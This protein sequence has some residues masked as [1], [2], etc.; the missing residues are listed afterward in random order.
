MKNEK[1][2]EHESYGMIQICRYRGGEKNFFGSAIPHEGGVSIEIFEGKHTRSLSSDWYFPKK[3]LVE[4]RLTENQ[5]A[6]CITNINSSPVPVT[7]KSIMGKKMEEPPQ[8]NKRDIFENEF[9]DSM[10]TLEEKLKN[11][12]AK[13]EEL[14]SQ[15]KN[16]NQKERDVILSEIAAI[17]QE[18]K[19]NIPFVRDCFREAMDDIVLE[20]K[21]EVE[22]FAKQRAHDLGVDTA[23]IG[24][25]P[26]Q[27]YLT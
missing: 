15:K 26:I 6:E 14:L 5:F 3:K 7:L 9:E 25:S 23:K 10:K 18:V 1:T 16:L 22:N 12:S 27:H 20:S 13:T 2:Y 11:L 8:I 19:N 4:I 24:D 21:T 17:R